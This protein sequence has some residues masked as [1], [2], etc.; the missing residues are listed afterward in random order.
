MQHLPLVLAFRDHQENRDLQDNLARKDP[1][2]R[3][4]FLVLMG[5]AVILVLM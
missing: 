1:R 4:V 5:L 2:V 3:L